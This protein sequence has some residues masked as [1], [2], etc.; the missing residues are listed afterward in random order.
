MLDKIIKDLGDNYKKED[1]DVVKNFIELYGTIAA[2]NSN[3]KAEDEK[4]YPYIYNAV[5]AAYIRRGS[6]GKASE[7]VGSISDSYDDIET[8]LKRD[9]ISVRKVI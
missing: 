6:E 1:E 9:V 7:T 8:K 5:K 3:R 4:L 2:N